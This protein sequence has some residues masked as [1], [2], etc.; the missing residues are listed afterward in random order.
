MYPVTAIAALGGHLDPKSDT[1]PGIV[2]LWRGT[3]A[4]LLVPPSNVSSPR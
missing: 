3:I 2:V 1:N 4:A